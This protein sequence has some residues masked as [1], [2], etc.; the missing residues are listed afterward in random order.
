[1]RQSPWSYDCI[2]G[3]CSGWAEYSEG[4]WCSVAFSLLVVQR[5][6]LTEWSVPVNEPV[7]HGFGAAVL[8]VSRAEG[9]PI[10]SWET[11][12][13]IPGEK[14]WSQR[15][16]FFYVR[17]SNINPPRKG[18]VVPFFLPVKPRGVANL[19][20]DGRHGVKTPEEQELSSAHGSDGKR[21]CEQKSIWGLCA[22]AL[23]PL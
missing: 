4:P 19:Q 15:I 12:I 16:F 23:I 21:E 10:W 1:M 14:R 20:R 22:M 13:V 11:Q 3:L 6:R 9:L 7:C 2:E 5:E 18:A 17:D 8:I